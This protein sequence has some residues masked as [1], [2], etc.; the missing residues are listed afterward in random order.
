[1]ATL[2]KSLKLGDLSSMSIPQKKQRVDDLFQAA[3]SPSLS[4]LQEEYKELDHEIQDLMH[5]Y[6][7]TEGDLNSLLTRSHEGQLPGDFDI[8]TLN[9]LLKLRDEVEYSI[10]TWSEPN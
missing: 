6:K 1:M 5:Q 9:I 8:C 3:L 2:T 4:D 7:I 10:K